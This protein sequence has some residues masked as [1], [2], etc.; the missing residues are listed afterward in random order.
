M[1]NKRKIYLKWRSELVRNFLFFRNI[2]SMC[3]KKTE[4]SCS[5]IIAL[6]MKLLDKSYF[7]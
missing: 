6:Q 3:W 5:D 2:S 7:V 4:H 1:C